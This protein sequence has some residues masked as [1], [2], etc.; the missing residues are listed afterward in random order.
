MKGKKLSEEH[1]RK[2]RIKKLGRKHSDETKERMTKSQNERW[3][4]LKESGW[5]SK[6]IPRERKLCV[7]C[8]KIIDFRAMRCYSCAKKGERTSWWKGGIASGENKK[9]YKRFKCLQRKNKKRNANGS[10]TLKEWKE[11]KE[12]IDLSVIFVRKKNQK[13][14]FL[15]IT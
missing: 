13:S 11:L 2:I 4:K 9:E 5:K 14:G 3:K 7:D 15:K 6:K 1:K 10:H 8:N 12:I